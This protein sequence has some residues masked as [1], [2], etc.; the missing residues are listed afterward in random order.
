MYFIAKI[1]L[2]RCF[3]TKGLMW[4]LNVVKLE[5]SIYT[6]DSFRNV[7]VV[8]QIYLF[9]F[10]A[11]PQTFVVTPTN[12]MILSI[13]LPRPSQ[14]IR[15][16][17]VCYLWTIHWWID[18]LDHCWISLEHHSEMLYLMLTDKSMYQG[19]LKSPTKG[20]NDWTNPWLQPDTQI[21]VSAWCKLYLFTWFG[22]SMT[23]PLSR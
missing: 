19:N 2:F 11:T 1:Y 16:P 9:I 15:V 21:L 4:S 12:V 3:V 17:D 6:L 18:S 20:R 7:G 14:L 23:N 5:I 22:F 13:A 8:F 10:D